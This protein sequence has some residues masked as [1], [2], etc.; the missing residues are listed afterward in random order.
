VD[1]V[2][3]GLAWLRR[4]Q[5]SL[6]RVVLALFCA[7]WLQA[8]VVPCVMAHGN[9]ATASTETPRHD[10][11]AGHAGHGHAATAAG[12]GSS[13][14]SPPCLYC[15]A[16]NSTADSC[17][18]HGGCAYPHDPQVDARAG[19]I[20]AAVPVPFFAPVPR[21]TRVAQRVDCGAVDPVPRISLSVSYCRFL[22]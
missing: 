18:G 12:H 17:D 3:F 15:P 22:E 7:A 20:F 1:R 6:A 13:D 8:A 21:V 5:R 19:A 16:D 14:A 9:T 4:R 10:G 11:H 2:D